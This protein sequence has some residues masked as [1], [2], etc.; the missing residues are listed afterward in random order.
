MDCGNTA[1]YEY[2][3]EAL[4]E[5]FCEP[6]YF[7]YFTV[8][9]FQKSGSTPKISSHEADYNDFPLSCKLLPAATPSPSITCFCF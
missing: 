4:Y 2:F 5:Y 3:C 7:I 1:L 9:S 6:L 8:L